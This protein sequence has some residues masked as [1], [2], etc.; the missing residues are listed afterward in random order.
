[1]V[2]DADATYAGR[3]GAAL[4]NLAQLVWRYLDVVLVVIALAP[5]LML[6]APVVGYLFGAVGWVLQRV[7]AAT[8][9]RWTG[10]VTAPVKRLGVDLFEAFGR[11]WLLAGVI[12]AAALV[13][14]RRDGL[15]AAVVIFCAYSVAFAIRVITHPSR[16]AHR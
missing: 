14:G 3:S 6:G 10:K 9:R 2:V 4:R 8:D 16:S 15:T 11:I 5:A 12:V 1:M 7:V 13:G